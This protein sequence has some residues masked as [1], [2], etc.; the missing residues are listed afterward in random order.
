MI[1]TIWGS[2]LAYEELYIRVT[3]T[4][5]IYVPM[6]WADKGY[7]GPIFLYIFYRIYDSLWQAT[8]Y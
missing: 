5:T 1:I 8:V 6:D 7:I 4:A 3:V 2:G